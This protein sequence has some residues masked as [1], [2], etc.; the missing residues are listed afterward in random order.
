MTRQTTD[1]RRADGLGMVA[2]TATY[3]YFLLYAQFGF[4]HALNE[5]LQA[6]SYVQRAMMFMGGAGI[7]ASL[8]VGFLLQY[9]SSRRFLLAGFLGAALTTWVASRCSA[10]ASFMM[11]ATAVG[12]FTAMITV[13]LAADLRGIVSGRHVGLSI[14]TA[15]GIAY[16]VCNIPRVF[17]G[18][19]DLQGLVAAG[20]CVVGAAA[21]LGLS[22][23]AARAA[24]EPST[25]AAVAGDFRGIGFIGVVLSFLALVWLDSAAFATIQ[26][27]EALK[28]QTW[29]APEQKLP[30]GAVH[31]VAAVLAG[32]LFDRG[33]FRS[34][35]MA[36]FGLF[37]VAFSSLNGGALPGMF[38]GPLYAVGISLYSVVLVIYPSA[39]ADEPGAV[40]ARWRAAI[41]FGVS[42]WIGSAL[43]VGM[44]QELHNIPPLFL[45][46][47]GGLIGLAWALSSPQ[48]RQ[49]LFLFRLPLSFAAVALV[50]CLGWPERY[51]KSPRATP[52][53]STPVQAVES[54]ALAQERGRRVYIQEGCIN[55]HSQYLRPG[56]QDEVQWGPYH[57]VDMAERPPLIGNRRQGPDL[58]NV[59]NR[60]S[61][62]WQRLHLIAPSAVSPGS[63]M[64][65]YRHLFS[66]G[67]T[68]GDELVAYLLSLGSDRIIDRVAQAQAWLPKQ[69]L[70]GSVHGGQKLF[71]RNCTPCHGRDGY[72]D[73]LLDDAYLRPALNLRK[74]VFW[75]AAAYGAPEDQALALARIVKFGL[76]GTSM[77]GHEYYTDR[78]IGHVVAYLQSLVTPQASTAVGRL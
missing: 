8:M 77:P 73:G 63:K 52:P 3:V 28:G 67:T 60:R 55:C 57:E 49:V 11:V 15:T 48:P 37:A 46:S 1:G 7:T 16:L 65:S 61:E 20:F 74:G 4:I 21:A 58:M 70:S 30:M 75:Y 29:A 6:E 72:G 66:E 9:I 27:T 40:P 56:T 51:E 59:G 18:S 71:Q 78:E 12:A 36:A 39:Q 26:E 10:P 34:I 35:L 19:A 64:P 47:A 22:S 76:P 62:D 38:A 69:P 31:L 44:A 23:P 5:H 32:W 45:W 42:G 14:G 50:L 24:P 33:H 13:S 2:V 53:A 68:R 41:L 54:T 25:P 43:G 17:E